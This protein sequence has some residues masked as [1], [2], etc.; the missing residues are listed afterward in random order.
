MRPQ[1]VADQTSDFKCGYWL[2]PTYDILGDSG[3]KVKILG[4][5][6][7]G[8]CEKKVHTNMCLILSG[9]W[10]TAPWIYKYKSNG[11]KEK[12]LTV[13]PISILIWCL[14][15]KLVT[16]HNKFLKT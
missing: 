14:N 3:E 4:G 9:Y 12:L 15:E 5:D 10:I 6:S 11:Y 13:N 16:I 2:S 1:Q 8:H 7:T